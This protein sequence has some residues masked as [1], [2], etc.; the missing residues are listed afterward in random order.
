MAFKTLNTGSNN[1]VAGNNDSWKAQAFINIYVPN[2]EG[3]KRKIGSIALKDA[4]AYDRKLIERL[5]QDDG[6]E[7]L[8]EVITVD[9]QM[10]DKEVASVGF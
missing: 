5:Q 6:L 2:G 1:N 3:G 4:R 10:A 7:S 9:F 8:M